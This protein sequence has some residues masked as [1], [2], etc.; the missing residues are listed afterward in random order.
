MV[1]VSEGKPG[2]APEAD[3]PTRPVPAQNGSASGPAAS[4]VDGATA[5]RLSGATAP[6]YGLR[7]AERDDMSITADSPTATNHGRVAVPSEAQA[8]DRQVA[9]ARTAAAARN[10]SSART[11]TERG[12]AP[13][14]PSY[15][16][17]NR[18]APSDR[19]GATSAAAQST[20]PQPSAAGATGGAPDGLFRPEPPVGERP[21]EE[22]VPPSRISGGQETTAPPASFGRG[23]L[24][25]VRGRNSR[26]GDAADE[27][28]QHQTDAT[29]GGEKAS[30]AAGPATTAASDGTGT[31]TDQT[32]QRTGST[33]ESASSAPTGTGRVGWRERLGL[34]P[35]ARKPEPVDVP[36][37]G[38]GVPTA[39]AAAAAA[40]AVSNGDR[41]AAMHAAP[42]AA[43]TAP[44]ATT[45]TATGALTPADRPT[46]LH[47]PLTPVTPA[48]P[49]ATKGPDTAIIPAVSAGVVAPAAPAAVAT[50]QPLAGAKPRAG[51]A[52]RTRKARLRLSRLDPWSVM[53]TS[54]LF[55]IA[56]GIVFVV[57]VYGVWTV[58]GA[59]GLFA[60]VDDIVKSVVSTPGD[61][62]PFR[63]EEYVNTQKVMG[64]A[65]IIAVV[66]VLILTALATLGSFLYNLAATVLGGLEVTLAE[67]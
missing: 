56:A 64:V 41:P 15:A 1:T 35:K 43:T 6:R 46:A 11:R 5:P 16:P 18:S 53:K 23:L 17:V 61:T 24:D 59:S 13:D 26:G 37:T 20:Q 30:E 27:V 34:A 4:G 42:G 58:L 29:V 31:G 38:S 25:R 14:G 32:S 52:R 60:S 63:V 54:F 7:E 21:A 51:A 40:A 8:P 66:D 2:G 67:D 36:P 55:S 45:R 47:S 19:A 3:T 10:A 50:A 44:G 22:K 9:E 12:S 48:H 62:T 28:S 65:A 39:A 49:A 57:A 33:D